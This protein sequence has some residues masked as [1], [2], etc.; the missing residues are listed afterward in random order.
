MKG[1]AGIVSK[2]RGQ[3]HGNGL[4]PTKGR[5]KIPKNTN[6]RRCICYI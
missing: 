5:K 1:I 2:S 3:S 6:L 4:K